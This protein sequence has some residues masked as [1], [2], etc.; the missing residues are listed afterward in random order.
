MV[1]NQRHVVKKM[2]SYKN[3]R[4]DTC[5]S[6]YRGVVVAYRMYELNMNAIVCRNT[7]SQKHIHLRNNS[8]STRAYFTSDSLSSHVIRES[9]FDYLA[10]LS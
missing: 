1:Y 7:A 6:S 10:V 8:W 5:K 3:L 9:T 4:E 2:F